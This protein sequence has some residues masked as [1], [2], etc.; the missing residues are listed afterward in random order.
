MGGNILTYIMNAIKYPESFYKFASTSAAKRWLLCKTVVTGYT[1]FI[2][3]RIGSGFG[4][5]LILIQ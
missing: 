5:I 4:P 3:I 1:V 2:S